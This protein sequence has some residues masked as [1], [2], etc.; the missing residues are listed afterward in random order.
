[1]VEFKIEVVVVPVS[2]VDRSK[3][4]YE[5]IGFR[6]DVDFCG[7]DGFRVVHLTP[8]GSAASLVIGS[9]VTDAAPGSGHGVHLVVDDVVAARAELAAAGVEVG[10]VFHDAVGVFHRAGTAGR[11]AGPHPERQSYG[12]FASF[13]DPD[14]NTFVLQEVTT[15]R[16]GRVGHVVYRSAAEV[17]AALRDAAL[18]HGVHEAELG[19]A[20][21]D[22]P[23]WYAAHMARAAGLGS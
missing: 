6:E 5:R 3:D 7:D 18:A 21:P 19:R 23:A 9:G 20:D 10:E 14:G 15:R 8:P 2:D 12:S 1:M 22:W 11:V 16:P 13:A 17:E 4:F